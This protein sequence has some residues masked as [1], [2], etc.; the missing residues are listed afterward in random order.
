MEVQI[1]G[2][3]AHFN[4]CKAVLPYMRKRNEG[5]IVYIS[6]GLIYR[7]MKGCA[8]YS[9]VKAGMSAFNKSLALEEAA[10]N[11]TVNIVAPGKIV[12]DTASEKWDEVDALPPLGRFASGADVAN[13]AISCLLPENAFITGQ[14]VYL[15]GGEIMPMP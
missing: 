7:F 15:A 4:I 9:A 2:M 10:K 6:G 1:V 3:K 8:A 5:R 13:A 11:I 12:T 14:T